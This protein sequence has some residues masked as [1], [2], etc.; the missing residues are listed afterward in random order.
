MEK[1]FEDF[2][3]EMFYKLVS[4]TKIIETTDEN[5]LIYQKGESA[6]YFYFVLKGSLSILNTD[7]LMPTSS[8]GLPRIPISGRRSDTTPR[9]VIKTFRDS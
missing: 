4:D 5:E 8:G 2:T 3:D 9:S 7:E 1:Y 6:D